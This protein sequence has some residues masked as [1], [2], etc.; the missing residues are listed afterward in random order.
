MADTLKSELLKEIDELQKMKP[1]K[2]VEHRLEKFAKMG[3]YAE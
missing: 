2:L 1:E 3:V